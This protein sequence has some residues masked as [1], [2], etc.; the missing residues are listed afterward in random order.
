M[1]STQWQR[2]K[3]IFDAA[4]ELELAVRRG[5]PVFFVQDIETSYYADRDV[6]G[7]VLTSY[8]PEFTY[9][10]TSRWVHER[11]LAHGYTAK[12]PPRDRAWG[13]RGFGTTDPNGV[14]ITVYH[15]LSDERRDATSAA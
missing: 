9:L 15:P 2:V 3:S 8:R 12:G 10:T 7:R 5:I 4:R 6:H 14:P 1:T 11:L 13:K